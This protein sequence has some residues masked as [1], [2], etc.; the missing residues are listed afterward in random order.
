MDYTSPPMPRLHCPRNPRPPRGRDDAS[1]SRCHDAP[2]RDAALPSHCRGFPSRRGVFRRVR[3]LPCRHPLDGRSLPTHGNVPTLASGR[4]RS[5]VCRPARSDKLHKRRTVRLLAF[6]SVR[7]SASLV[8]LPRQEPFRAA[9][10]R[11]ALHAPSPH[12]TRL[13]APG[14]FRPILSFSG[15]VPYIA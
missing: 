10:G 15:T 4:V 13:Q 14:T 1:H 12:E 8:F 7:L 6:P 9:T 3:Q 2:E 5:S 11:A